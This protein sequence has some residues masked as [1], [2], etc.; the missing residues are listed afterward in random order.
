MAQSA[1]AVDQS[2]GQCFSLGFRS[3]L[4]QVSPLCK[5]LSDVLSSLVREC[6]TS[7]K[8]TQTA[9]VNPIL[10]Q[11]GLETLVKREAYV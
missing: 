2:Q 10:L 1:L 8:Q 5:L 11:K 7:L 3:R 6:F 9:E 4:P